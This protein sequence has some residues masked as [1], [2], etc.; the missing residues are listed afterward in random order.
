MLLLLEE[1]AIL[2]YRL[3]RVARGPPF[4]YQELNLR[5]RD[6]QANKIESFS[7]EILP[8]SS[9]I[10]IISETFSQSPR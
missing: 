3:K 9:L 5:R 8:L 4:P 1:I 6:N 10:Q 2:D 7:L